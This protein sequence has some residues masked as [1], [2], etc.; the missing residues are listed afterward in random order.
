LDTVDIEEVR[1]VVR[2]GVLDGVTT[3]SMLF[4]KTSGE[5]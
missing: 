2:W 3:N 4:V 1:T 5:T